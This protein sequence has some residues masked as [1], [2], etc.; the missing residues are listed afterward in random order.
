MLPE[1]GRSKHIKDAWTIQLSDII[2]QITFTPCPEARDFG[3]SK[4]LDPKI[5]KFNI[6]KFEWSLSKT[7][8]AFFSRASN[9]SFS[10]NI[11]QKKLFFFFFEHLKSI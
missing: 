4:V 5:M 2:P 6:E 10:F 1:V 7:H 8:N 9:L 3:D 11:E